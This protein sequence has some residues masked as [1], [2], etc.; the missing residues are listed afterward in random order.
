[1]INRAEQKEG[2]RHNRLPHRAGRHQPVPGRARQ[3]CIDDDIMAGCAGCG[4]RS[5][6]AWQ[7][8]DLLKTTSNTKEM[9]NTSVQSTDVAGAQQKVLYVA[10]YIACYT[11]CMLRCPA[12]L[13]L[14]CFAVCTGVIV[15]A[16]GYKQ[17]PETVT[18]LPS[19]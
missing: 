12:I 6:Q 11:Y 7:V 3:D 9:G 1:V 10:Y 5:A 2:S 8:R 14:C 18:W 17:Q 19:T 4:L 16:C 15:C 13:V